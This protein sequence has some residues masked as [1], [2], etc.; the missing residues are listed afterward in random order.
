M[1]S[2]CPVAV[3]VSGAG[4]DFGGVA[5]DTPS[6]AGAETYLDSWAGVLLGWDLARVWES[7]LYLE[8]SDCGRRESFCWS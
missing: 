8:F 1:A 6:C 3:P 4:C 2:R 5:W 7:E